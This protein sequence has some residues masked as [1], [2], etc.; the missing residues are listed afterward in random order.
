MYIEGIPWRRKLVWHLMDQRMT[1]I[2]TVLREKCDY[3][4]TIIN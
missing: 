4:G 1:E 2:I 3:H